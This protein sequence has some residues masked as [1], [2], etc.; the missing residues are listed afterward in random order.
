MEMEKPLQIGKEFGLEGEKLLEFVEK[1]QQLEEEREEKRRQLEEEKEERRRILEEDRRKEEEEKEQRRR[2][3]DE[4]REN[5]RQERELRKLEMEAELLR[6][7][8]AIEAAKREHEL[9]LARLAQGRN[10]AERAELREDRAK[11][12]KLPSFVDGKDDLD[13]YLQ[14]FERFATTA[15]WE[16]T[17]WASKLSAL[18]SGRA[19]EVY[20]RLSKEAAQDYDRVKLALMKRYDLTEDGYRRKFRASKPEVDESPEQFIVRLDRYLLRWLELSNTERSFE[21]LKD[22]I[23]KEQFIDSCPKELAIHLR[24][25]APESLVQIA[26]IADQYLEAHGKHLFSPASRKP[27][28]LPQK[29]ETRNQQSDSTMVVCFKCNARGHRAVNCPSLIKKCFMCGKQGHEARNCRSGKQRS[30]GQN[31]N[32]LPLQRGQVSAGCLVKPPEVKPTEEEVRA[33]IKDDKLLL[34]SG[35]KIPI[36]SNACLEP[37]SGDR[38]KMPVV[39]GRVGEKTVDVLRDTGCSGIVVKKNL[40]SEDQFTG[41]FNVMLLIDNTARKVA[42]ARITVDTPYLKGQV[43]AQCLPD[44][45]YDLIIGNVP[46]ARPADEPD[47]TWQE[48]CAVTT[49]SQA[50]KD[51]VV[52]PLKVPSYQESPIVDKQNLKQMQSEDESLRKYWDRDEATTEGAVAVLKADNRFEEDTHCEVKGCEVKDAEDDDNVDFLEIGCYDAKE[53]VADVATGSNLT[54]EQR[55]EF[56]D[57]ANQFSSLFT[58]APGTTDLAQHHIKL[59]SDEPVRSRPYPVPYSMRESLKK[60]IADMIKMRVIRESDSPYASPVVVVKKKDNT[61][62]VCVDY[63][64]LNKL[65]V[66]DPEPM[67][68]AEHL[69]QKL[70]GDKFFTKINLS[71]GYWQITIPEED[72]PK[73]AFVTPDGSYEFLKMPFGMINSAAT[74]KRAMRKLIADLDNVD[75]YWDDI[76]VHTRTWEEH[77]KALRELF[78]RLLRA[79]MTIRPT[80]CIFGASCVDF[81]GH[82]LEQGV[83]GLHE[84]NVEKIKNAPWPGTKKQVRSFVGLAG[85]YR[86]FI[87]NF[88]AIAAPLSD[89]TRKGQPSRVEWGQ[90]QEKAYQTI[91]S[92]L[93]NEPILRLPDP[94]KTYYLQTDASNTGIGAVLMQKHDEKLFPV[95]YASKKLS[96]TERNYSTIEKECLAVVWGIKRFHLYLYGVPFVLQTDH[97]PLKYMNSAKFANGRLMRWAMFLQSYTF[98]VEAIKG[99]ENVGA[100]YLS[101]A[102][103]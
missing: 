30:G 16:K 43:E 59:T 87:P 57:L 24:E 84:E 7:K 33:C 70:S 14:R 58:E 22:L 90:A 5:R 63:R 95:C 72:I 71:K 92:H 54:D 25:R 50:K 21:G 45:I 12:P 91:K 26:K 23:V 67:P 39:K 61:N 32:G 73:T 51:G 62:R 2:K 6:Q 53:S 52:S 28:V 60:D 29:E 64:K 10:V 35:K 80:K 78:A 47:P 18:L 77:I 65:T 8:E 13:A 44:A 20:S 66:I 55:S 19:L 93:T 98:R 102:E 103:E 34:A 1:Q 17:G 79:G 76:L 94:K 36:V 68:T 101:R 96:S 3:E 69:F 88:A 83:L 74:L 4:E 40:V 38:L 56:M 11:A 41:D 75:F 9:E 15:K 97:E 89:L 81:L 27:V 31:R 82:R 49:R 99:S 48:A 86:D 42:I 100:D 46:G 37:L 85:Y